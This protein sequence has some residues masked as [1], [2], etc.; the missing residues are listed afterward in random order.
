[1]KKRTHQV[2]P[3]HAATQQDGPTPSLSGNSTAAVPPQAT[4][5]RQVERPRETCQRVKR[6]RSSIWRDVRAGTFPSPIKLS[7]G[8]SIGFFAD[9]IDAWLASR[10][11]VRP[12]QESA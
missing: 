1:M 8:G 12:S 11:R 9:E 5:R 7:E 4:P 10:P 6:S 3:Q 2:R